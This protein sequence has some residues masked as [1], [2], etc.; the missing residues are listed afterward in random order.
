M[1]TWGR[2]SAGAWVEVTE[3]AS[4]FQ[5]M[6]WVTSLCQALKL[7]PGESPFYSNI[8]IPAQQSV[9]TQVMPDFYIAQLQS[10]YAQYFT[11]LTISKVQG[12]T[13]DNPVSPSYNIKIV[14]HRGAVINQTIVT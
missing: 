12:A 2:N 10:Q 4:G 7:T 6:I 3:D 13:T 8:G 1:K 14:T 5:D 11:S 9:V